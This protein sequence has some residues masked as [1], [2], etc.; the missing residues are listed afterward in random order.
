MK[1]HWMLC[2]AMLLTWP[3]SAD[4]KGKTNCALMQQLAQQHS[5][6]M[7]RRESLDHSGF[8]SRAARGARAENVAMGSKTKAGAIAQWW[9]SPGHASNM[10]LPGCKAVAHAVSRSGRYYWTMLIGQ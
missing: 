1:L 10:R 6:S 5:N 7:A 3:A 2:G 9:G 4:A 8:Y